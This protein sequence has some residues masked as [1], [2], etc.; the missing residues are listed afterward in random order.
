MS[1][2][3]SKELSKCFQLASIVATVLVISIHYQ[4]KYYIQGHDNWNYLIQEFLTNGI[5]RVAVPFFALSSGFFFFL[6][7]TGLIS[8]KGNL[9]KRAISILIPYIICSLF[10]FVAQYFYLTV[11]KDLSYPLDF[12][13]FV[14]KIL[15]VPVSVQ[16]W[17]LRDLMFL[18]LISPLLFLLIKYCATL[19]LII[20]SVL[21][22]SEIQFMPTLGGKYLISIETLFFF[23]SGGFL[24]TKIEWI[25]FALKQ[26]TKSANISVIVLL[27]FL[28]FLRIFIDPTFMLGYAAYDY[29][30]ASLLIYKLYIVAGVVALLSMSYG[31]DFKG[32]SYMASFTFFMFLYHLLPLSYVVT[33]LGHFLLPD[34]YVFY[35]NFPVAV[36][37]TFFAAYILS[38]LFPKLY[39]VLSGGRVS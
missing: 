9:R 26:V 17:F 19:G 18:F 6:K 7:Y 37:L 38:K 28:V 16:L 1:N 31:R 25:D 27:F 30:I 39:S 15:I 11:L 24:V 4:S 3:I 35:F 13:S 22:F 21:W 5:A 23:Y 34:A 29:G 12:W 20:I 32:L 36:I 8:Y 33:K 2:S 14:H 10:M